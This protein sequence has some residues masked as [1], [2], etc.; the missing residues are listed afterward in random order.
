M[1]AL[2]FSTLLITIAGSLLWSFA[3]CMAVFSLYLWPG[4]A[5]LRQGL[6]MLRPLW[7]FVVVVLI[8]HWVTGALLQGFEISLRLV[9]CVGLANLVTM[10]TRLDDMLTV[11]EGLLRPLG[12]FGLDPKRLSIALALVIRFTPSLVEKGGKL[13]EAWRAR[14]AKRPGWRIVLPFSL[15]AIDD[16]EHISDALRA[17]GGLN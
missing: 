12:R 15:I 13:I 7:I 14:S 17:R 16:A 8:W 11:T 10:T 5:F 9:A 1:L 2:C 3:A 6:R 4:L